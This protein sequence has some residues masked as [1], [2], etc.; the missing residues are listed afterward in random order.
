MTTAACGRRR[1]G[2]SSPPPSATPTCCGLVAEV[3][4][5][6]VARYGGPDETP[7]DP[8]MFE[9]PTGSFFLGYLGERP[10]ATGAWR[11]TTAATVPGLPPGAAVAEVKRMYVSPTA[12]RRGLARRMLAHL[13]A[14]ATA[15]GVRAMVLE[16]GTAQ[17][18]AIALYTS[19]GYEPIA[20]FG[21]Y[22]DS[23]LSRCFGR[24]LPGAAGTAAAVPAPEVL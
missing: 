24:I 21:H 1:A 11:R 12:Q 3:Q 7:L 14:T 22:R 19:S 8:A 2:G 9:P 5:V 17:P 18:E 10:V 23:P 4:A 16:T 6:Y 20:G 15:S 13:E